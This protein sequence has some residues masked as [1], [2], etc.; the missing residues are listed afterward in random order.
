[1]RGP[2]TNENSIEV[3]FEPVD[4]DGGSTIRTYSIEMSEDAGVTFV[5][6]STASLLISPV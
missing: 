2:N 5:A 1:M 4:D 6:V 3:E